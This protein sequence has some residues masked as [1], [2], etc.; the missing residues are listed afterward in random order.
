MNN[1][2]K[3]NFSNI[4]KKKIFSENIENFA[5]KNSS[6]K[7]LSFLKKIKIENKIKIKKIDSSVFLRKKVGKLYLKMKEKL[8]LENSLQ[9][10]IRQKAPEITRK[11]IF[12]K[13]IA[14]KPKNNIRVDEILPGVFEIYEKN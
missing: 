2:K 9:K 8:R 13:I 6:Q 11:E 10:M 14:L 5:N 12:E 1:Y 3:I 4:I 7:I